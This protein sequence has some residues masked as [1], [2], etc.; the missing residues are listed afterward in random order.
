MLLEGKMGNTNRSVQK[1]TSVLSQ[2]PFPHRKEK[3]KSIV[4]LHM[5]FSRW[6]SGLDWLPQLQ[7]QGFISL[8]KHLCSG[9]DQNLQIYA[10]HFRSETFW[11]AVT[12]I[13]HFMQG[14]KRRGITSRKTQLRGKN[15]TQ[16]PAAKAQW[17]LQ[18]FPSS[19]VYLQRTTSLKHPCWSQCCP[20]CCIFEQLKANTQM[21]FG[22]SQ[23]KSCPR[24]MEKT[25]TSS[26]QI[27]SMTAR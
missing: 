15:I 14:L 18:W 5:C 9:K 16:P 24:R 11:N 23:T 22:H 21:Y 1:F 27:D 8:Q 13:D 25:Q 17:D 26:H 2:L 4:P 20:G 6:K 12:S 19:Q 7:Q 3:W 10:S